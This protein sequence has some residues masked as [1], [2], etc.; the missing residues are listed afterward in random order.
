MRSGSTIREANDMT[1]HAH[2]RPASQAVHAGEKRP[3]SHGY[4]TSQPISVATAYAYDDTT[5]LDRA[6]DDPSHGFVY[7]RF[8]NPTVQA[9]ERAVAALEETDEAI[10]FASGMA[11]IHAAVISAVP[12]GGTILA[13]QDVYGATYTLLDKDL[14]RSGVTPEFVDILD[15]ETVQRLARDK[16]PAAILAETV[17]NPLLRVADIPALAR[18]AREC[19][20][21]LIIDNTFASPILCKPATIGADYVIH[22]TTKYLGGHGDSTGGVIATSSDRAAAIR[23]FLKLTGAILSPFEAWITH[24]GVK[25]LPLRMRA[26][27]EN[28]LAVL[29]WLS[30][31]SRIE[32][33]FYP[34]ISNSVP[35]G[36]FSTESRGAMIAF[37]IAGAAREEIFAF[38]DALEMIIPAPTLG[39]VYSLALYPA[40]ASHRGHTPER[41]AE[42]GIRDNLV[43]ISVGIEDVADIIDD[44]DR[45]LTKAAGVR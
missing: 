41:R 20:A 14:R 22:S 2:L 17:S 15:L 13:S 38:L 44:L 8:G 16:Q 39:D 10:A 9:F 25:T 31:D 36:V 11:A 30:N 35:D 40:M 24:R 12:A 43:R 4:P 27:G 28:A 26:H 29:D 18:I 7:S 21:A 3:D 23:G 42:I 32:R 1:D 19:G 34:G 6:F 33:V 5:D 37:E 45:A